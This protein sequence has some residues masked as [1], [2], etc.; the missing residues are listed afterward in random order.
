MNYSY[1]S[2]YAPIDFH[3]P[4]KYGHNIQNRS[5]PKLEDMVKKLKIMR[6]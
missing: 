6:R 2:S 3:P 4:E 1:N 5:F